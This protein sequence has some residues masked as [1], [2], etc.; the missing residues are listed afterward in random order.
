MPAGGFQ[1]AFSD[2]VRVFK[3]RKS[4]LKAGCSQDWPPHRPSRPDAPKT[5][6][7]FSKPASPVLSSSPIP[8]RM[9][10]ALPTLFG[11][12]ADLTAAERS[13]FFQAHHT[14]T[15][16]AT[17]IESLLRFDQAD[18]GALA[19]IVAANVERLDPAHLGAACGPYKLVR[20]LGQGGMGSV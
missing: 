15:E 13:A 12:V 3:P 7:H 4:R 19:G 1:A 6:K 11:E 10:P 20:L 14:P 17:E 8:E 9:D 5:F 2:R 16:L 18:Y